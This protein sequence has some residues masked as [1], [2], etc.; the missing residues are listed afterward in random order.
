MTPHAILGAAYAVY[1][2]L[3]SG[4][5]AGAGSSQLESSGREGGPGQEVGVRLEPEMISSPPSPKPVTSK[6]QVSL[7]MT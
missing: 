5:G 3:V 2:R 7:S 1:V 4:S 6:M